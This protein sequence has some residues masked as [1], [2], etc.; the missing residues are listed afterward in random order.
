MTT[1][2]QE[3]VVATPEYVVLLLESYKKDKPVKEGV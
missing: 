2:T 3:Y 1:N